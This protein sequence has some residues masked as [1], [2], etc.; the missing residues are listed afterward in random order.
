MMSIIMLTGCGGTPGTM[1]VT[2]DRVSGGEYDNSAMDGGFYD[3]EH[4]PADTAEGSVEN[5]RQT[6]GDS[7]SGDL[8]EEKL[9][10]RCSIDM[11]TL[12]YEGTVRTIKESVSRYGGIIQSE[13]ESD[14]GYGWYYDDY[15]KTDG[16]LHNQL[17][18]RIPSGNYAEFVSG[19]GNSGKI[20]SKSTSVDNISQEYYDTETQ[21]NALEIQSEKLLQMFDK[22]ETIEE[23]ITVEQRLSEI[24]YRL[25]GLRTE[26][27]YMDQDVAYS[28]VDISITEVME[29]KADAVPSKTARFSD[30][31][32]N[33]IRDTG[34]G[35][36]MT[37]EWLLFFVIRLLPYMATAGVICCVAW[38][39]RKKQ[40][41]RNIQKGHVKPYGTQ[42]SHERV[43]MPDSVNGWNLDGKPQTGRGMDGILE[44]DSD[45]GAG[46]NKIP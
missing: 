35:F 27:R 40:S 11:E 14:I 1:S 17:E 28:Y 36:M 15:V 6:A 20:T 25:D 29:Y 34:K 23:M 26:K 18:V 21:I 19:I 13:D 5:G 22:C 8:L 41:V 3:V 2:T 16:T 39:K 30:R 46:G 9:V 42:C 7:D 43:Q 31:L 38:K 4:V 12:D 37:A 24:Q 33:T 45:R 32:K 10:Y 44:N